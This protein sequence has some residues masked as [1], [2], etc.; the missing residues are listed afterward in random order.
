MFTGI[1]TA[2]G[3]AW[4]EGSWGLRVESQPDFLHEVVVGESIATQGV[5][6]TVVALGLD[7]FKAALSQE[8]LDRTVFGLWA[9]A[10]GSYPVNLERSLRL[11]DRLSGHYVLGHVDT[12]IQCLKIVPVGDAR[13]MYFSIPTDPPVDLTDLTGYRC[14]IVPKGSVALN[15]VSLTVNTVNTELAFFTVMVIPHTLKATGLGQLS[16]GDW[17][18]LEIDMLARYCVGHR[19][20]QPDLPEWSVMAG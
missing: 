1:V 14:W 8:T 15:G 13:S 4:R 19:I 12:R 7:Y 5:C 20:Y 9:D 16:A 2:M 11:S 18:N 17:V 3:H 6:L 10:G